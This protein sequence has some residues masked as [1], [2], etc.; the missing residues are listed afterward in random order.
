MRVRDFQVGFHD[1]DDRL[2]DLSLDA[3]ENRYKKCLEFFKRAED[4]EPKLTDHADKINLRVFKA[5]MQ[6]FIEGYPF[7]GYLFP[8]NFNEG[9][10][11][12]FEKLISWMVFETPKDYEKMLSRL[13]HIPTQIDQIIALM[14]KGVEEDLVN[15]AISMKS[16][17]DLIGRFIVTNAEDSPTY[18]AFQSFGESFS[19][20]QIKDFQF[21]AKRVIDQKVTPAF[22]K[23]QDYVN[24]DYVTRDEIAVTSLP[25]GELRYSQIVNFHTSTV[26]LPEDIH[27]MGLDEVKRIQ[28]EM[29]KIVSE[30][31]YDMSVNDFSNMIKNESRFFYDNADDLLRGF[32]DIV[33]D[34][35][36][37][38]LAKLKVQAAPSADGPHA[39]YLSGSYDGTRPGVFYVNTYHFDATPK[40]EMMTLSL[41]EGNPGHHLQGSHTLESTT[42]PFFRSAMEDRNYCMAPS[43]FPMYTYYAEGWGL[44]AES[45]GFD[46]GLFDDPYDRYGHYSDEIFRACR[47]VVDTGM[48]ALGWTRQE[49]INFLYTHTAMTKIEVENEIDRYI[50]WPGQA[51]AY[52]IGQMK[53]SELR[54]KASKEMGRKFNLG[55]FHDVVLESYGPMSIL[56]EEVNLWIASKMG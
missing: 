27:Q 5:E 34:K 9:I 21:R 31:G 55:E 11:V 41:H 8:I 23:L 25:D 18:T 51:L 24:N 53:I 56:E 26:K 37:P 40:Y 15:H 46:L 30:L 32:K 54:E 44:Y 45:V 48:H 33:Y 16:V 3:F 39:F 17:S 36:E 12:D 49:A 20:A 38:L 52:K 1:N 7:K 43:R 42:M 4:I 19:P 50:N 35:I 28:R 47:L 29:A 6:T 22:R 13:G 10:H 2:D 14:R